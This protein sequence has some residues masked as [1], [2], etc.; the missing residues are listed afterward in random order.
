MGGPYVLPSE[1]FTMAAAREVFL[2]PSSFAVVASFYLLLASS[3]VIK[4]LLK[5]LANY[6]RQVYILAYLKRD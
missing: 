4:T 1:A 2:S 5:T 6:H 3:Y